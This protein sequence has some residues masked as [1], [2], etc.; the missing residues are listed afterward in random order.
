MN[1]ASLLRPG[2]ALVTRLRFMSWKLAL[3]IVLVLG[4]VPI[5]YFPYVYFSELNGTIRFAQHELRGIE[6][7]GPMVDLIRL[8][9]Q[10]RGVATRVLTDESASDLPLR[11]IGDEA[12][13][14]AVGLTT[15]LSELETDLP[16]AAA[17]W[18]SLH[19]RWRALRRSVPSLTEGE[20]FEEHVLLIEELLALLTIVADD[21]RLTLD[22]ELETYF[23][24]LT[25]TDT[26]PALSEFMGRQRALTSG[27]DMFAA[28][29]DDLHLRLYSLQQ[30]VLAAAERTRSGL[31]RL[32]A[33]NRTLEDELGKTAV[34]ALDTAIALQ[35]DVTRDILEAPL[36]TVS[37]AE[38][39]DRFTAAIDTVFAAH[40]AATDH[41]EAL[42][43]AR[44]EAATGTRN[45]MLPTII[46]GFVIATYLMA[47]TAAAAVNDLNE[48]QRAALRMAAGDLTGAALTVKGKDE[49]SEV[50]HAMNESTPALR[51]LIRHVV[52][53]SHTLS[54][55]S[56]QLAAASE[57]SA[58]AAEGANTSVH[59]VAKGAT[60]QVEAAEN[61][62]R[63]ME[64]LQV[65]GQQIAEGS[66]QSALD[67]Q[68]ASRRLADMTRAV[69]GVAAEAHGV[70]Q[71]TDQAALAART[72]A[73]VATEA[74]AAMVTIR[75][76][77]GAAA[78]QIG[79]LH[80]LS[81]QIGAISE[82]ISDIAG[83][84]N[85]L[86]LNAAI[87]AA[88]AGEHGRGFAVVADEV[89]G[90]AEQSDRSAQQIQQLID[91]IQTR[92]EQA[93]QGMGIGTRHVDDGVALVQDT[94]ATLQRILQ[95]TEQAAKGVNAIAAAAVQVQADGER[96]V[97]LFQSVASVTDQSAA[98]ARQVAAGIHA[99][100][101]ETASVTDI[102]RR[103]ATTAEE[104]SAAM[105]EL[106]ATAEEVSASA[107]SLG[108]IASQLE[109][110]CARFTV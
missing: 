70:A 35:A 28:P 98:A 11:Q 99:G 16:A 51:Q 84:T 75:D 83:Q 80:D 19:S 63:I 109:R 13:R 39:F 31:T 8:V 24:M 4:I 72:G 94:G 12:D 89:R 45:V 43:T 58:E 78:E 17:S 61:N 52:E 76:A 29:D 56:A 105:E 27:L 79:A 34:G 85:L 71:E 90:L 18:P 33:V 62:A 5:S 21:A 95:T 96:I 69:E 91:A 46:A 110:R 32:F 40:R 48:L 106:T 7:I 77:V 57:Q 97:E 20:S 1:F 47:S 86:A 54:A 81:E 6:L 88:R 41:L 26:L 9:Q 65:A 64:Q 37:S 2:I 108:E 36:V 92:V 25:A 87:E 100:A 60:E 3:T 68:D 23:L 101:E 15:A 93:A 50:M 104:V 14:I 102:A 66:A 49:L 10:H 53:S 67:V 30:D 44:L 38:L 55:T 42:V 73:D 107:I 82:M 22:P 103:N 59:V 74:A